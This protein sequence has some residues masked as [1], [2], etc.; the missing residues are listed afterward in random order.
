M[1]LTGVWALKSMRTSQRSFRTSK[2]TF[3]LFAST[4]SSCK[5]FLIWRRERDQLYILYSEVTLKGGRNG[6]NGERW[7]ASASMDRPKHTENNLCIKECF[8][9]S[10][11]TVFRNL[12][13]FKFSCK[14]YKHMNSSVNRTPISQNLPTDGT[15]TVT[16]KIGK[17]LSTGSFSKFRKWFQDPLVF[18]SS[19]TIIH[20]ISF[21]NSFQ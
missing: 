18:P 16:G 9:N 4:S 19:R 13:S 20:L 14:L 6:M 17:V 5:E 1:S 21:L 7:G 12:V 2:W 10:V 3:L 15:K 11:Y 8:A